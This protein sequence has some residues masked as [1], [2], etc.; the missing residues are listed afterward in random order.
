MGKNNKRLI[1]SIG[2]FLLIFSLFIWHDLREG[3]VYSSC[4]YVNSVGTIGNESYLLI[5]CDKTKVVG[6]QRV[7]LR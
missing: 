4:N 1:I 5:K 7:V 3:N 6:I 2:L